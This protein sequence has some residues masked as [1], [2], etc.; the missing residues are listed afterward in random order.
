MTRRSKSLRKNPEGVNFAELHELYL[1]LEVE[2][3]G[4]M[5]RAL[6]VMAWADFVERVREDEGDEYDDRYEEWTPGP[7]DD[8]DD[9][10]PATP[11][12]LQDTAM[13]LTQAIAEK[14]D[15]AVA[16]GGPDDVEILR[17]IGDMEDEEKWAARDELLKQ[18]PYPLALLYVRALYADA[19]ED[20]P[21]LTVR[22]AFS[23]RNSPLQS[24]QHAGMSPA[25]PDEFGSDLAMMGLGT[26]VS[27]FD[28]HANFE[29]KMPRGEVTLVSPSQA[30]DES[31]HVEWWFG[32]R[33]G[34]AKIPFP[35]VVGEAPPAGPYFRVETAEEDDD[36]IVYVAFVEINVPQ[37][38]GNT[39]WAAEGAMA[40]LDDPDVLGV[41][42]PA[43]YFQMVDSSRWNRETQTIYRN[44]R[45]VQYELRNSYQ[46]EMMTRMLASTYDLNE[47]RM[48]D[49]VWANQNDWNFGNNRWVIGVRGGDGDKVVVFTNGND[50]TTA[51]D[52]AADWV[53]EAQPSLV[54]DT[55]MRE[56][57]DQLVQEKCNEKGFPDPDMLSEAD[58]QEID[59][60][61]DADYEM[62]GN[63]SAAFDR[64]TFYVISHN[65]T[66]SAL[67]ELA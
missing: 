39:G 42:L 26:G 9:Y 28:D 46:N 15:L 11:D 13:S 12:P 40:M 25:R 62:H 52:I 58:W 55:Q 37:F 67:M 17:N 34:S 6:W 35:D 50:L 14:N 29:L 45:Q 54:R 18:L 2:I 65:P 66:V 19:A 38:P 22:Y 61:V 4:A 23:G 53:L 60:Q 30:I 64:D 57:R 33:R 21:D 32:N 24:E 41:D 31:G 47:W 1:E 43:N 48:G 44:Y 56:M 8:W 63:Y 36:A 59:E 3:R 27:W 7:G 5:A 49:L 16:D 10:A 51:F 20:R